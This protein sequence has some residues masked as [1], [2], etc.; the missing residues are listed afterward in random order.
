MK[1]LTMVFCV[2]MAC[3]GLRAQCAF[4]LQLIGDAGQR[5]MMVDGKLNGRKVELVFDTGASYNVITPELARLYGL[6]VSN[7][8]VVSK[9]TRL[10]RGRLATASSLSLGREVM[11]NV[12][13]VVLDI[14]R[15]NESAAENMAALRVV[16]GQTLL[17][18]WAGYTLDFVGRR[19]IFHQHVTRTAGA[20]PLQVSNYGIM[21]VSAAKDGHR[22]SL[23]LDTGATATTLGPSYYK[24]FQ[25][26]IA[27][28]GKWDITGSSGYG[29]VLYSSV[30]RMPEICLT[31][32]GHRC[33]L[34]NVPVT[35]LSTEKQTVLS[36]DGRLGLDFFR[37]WQQVTIDNS[38][39][40]IA[41]K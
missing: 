15:G 13:F 24:A 39:K 11:K 7:R 9:G 27:R 5:L 23:T 32:G 3:L 22:F 14:G 4:R 16:I 6:K 18:R 34:K 31:I 20:V 36:G 38:N 8:S 40:T 2:L 1:R 37:L 41:F 30:F 25:A 35:T 26:E 29:G 17:H 33:C 12:E 10:T 28:Y 21:S 19:I